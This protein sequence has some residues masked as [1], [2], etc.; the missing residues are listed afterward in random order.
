MYQKVIIVGNLGGDPMLRYTPAGD[1]VTSFSMA[2]NRRWSGRDG[3]PVEETTW[4]RVSVWGNQAEACNQYLVKGSQV[5]VEGR[6]APD[7]ATGGPRLWT[8]NDGT[9]RASYE[10]RA[11]WVQF[12]ARP[13]SG[14]NGGRPAGG[15]EPYHED[16]PEE[17]IPF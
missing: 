12:L 13:Q 17:D 11:L 6:L 8:A 4:F 16:V 5:L 15:G 9:V 10:I 3:Q 2:A 14:G 1:A 7:R